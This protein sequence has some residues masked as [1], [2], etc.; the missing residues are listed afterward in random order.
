MDFLNSKILITGL[1][2]HQQ[3]VEITFKTKTELKVVFNQ[4]KE[5]M[6]KSNYMYV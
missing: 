2:W 1:S 3:W 5:E 6:Q 4:K